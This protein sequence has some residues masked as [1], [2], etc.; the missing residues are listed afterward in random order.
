MV[1]RAALCLVAIGCAHSTAPIANRAPDDD[2]R[3]RVPELCAAIPAAIDR[4]DGPALRGVRYVGPV[5]ESETMNGTEHFSWQATSPPSVR[6][7][8]VETYGGVP[9][10]VWIEAASTAAEVCAALGLGVDD[11]V[12]IRRSGSVSITV[13]DRADGVRVTC[14]ARK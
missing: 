3:V 1:T 6:A 10:I 14:V 8:G 13:G 4:V 5:H 9:F 7:V 2:W 11:G 12:C